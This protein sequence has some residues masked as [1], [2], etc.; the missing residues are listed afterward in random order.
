MFGGLPR[1]GLCALVADP[2]GK[3]KARASAAGLIFKA[4]LPESLTDAPFG[5]AACP[6]AP[7]RLPTDAAKPGSAPSACRAAALGPQTPIQTIGSPS[8]GP[9]PSMLVPVAR[10]TGAASAA[11]RGRLPPVELSPVLALAISPPRRSAQA[12]PS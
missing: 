1:K 4:W 6:Y 2:V 11:D 9:A 8:V 12:E 7:L 10:P 3:R 5:F